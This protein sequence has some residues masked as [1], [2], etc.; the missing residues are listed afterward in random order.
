MQT[1]KGFKTTRHFHLTCI[2][3]IVC[4]AAI[5]TGCT[6]GS[7]PL[8]D[9]SDR[10]VADTIAGGNRTV[11]GG[12]FTRHFRVVRNGVAHDAMVL[13]APV[14]IRLAL[15]APAPGAVLECTSTPVFNIGDGMQLDV[16][17]GE[18]G[19]RRVIFSRYY[20]AGRRLE[21]RAWI[22]LSIP[23]ELQASPGDAELEIRVSGGPQGD[24]VADWLALSM[25]RIVQN[26]RRQ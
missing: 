7:A 26:P 19:R 12:S 14:T 2:L 13:E 8:P 16:L 21:D 5:E 11:G 1:A 15:A 18:G 25:V 4:A 20:D 22:P 23:L 24:L 10:F 3:L 9:L 17:L 6:V